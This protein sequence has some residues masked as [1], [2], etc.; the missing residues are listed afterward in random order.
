MGSSTKRIFVISAP[1][2][3][4]KTTVIK[5]LLDKIPDLALS[6]S[7]TT[8]PMRR[9]EKDGRDYY[10][11]TREVFQKMLTD[12]EFL[13]W[14]ETYGHL[15]GTSKREIDRIVALGKDVLMDLD[16]NGALNIKKMYP[17][18]VLIFLLPPSFEELKERIIKRG[19]EDKEEI[20]KRLKG[21]AAEYE[22]R[23]E[24]DYQVVNED[25]LEACSEIA[26]IVEYVRGVE[27]DG[28]DK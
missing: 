19:S 9:N 25:V 17:D 24:Y 23:H 27:Q 22:R 14:T 10:F 6:V 21:A 3:T 20:E 11:V 1:S 2:G 26:E 15:Y 18:A 12:G 5:C 16:T 13:E 8:R 28:K 7:H 4:G